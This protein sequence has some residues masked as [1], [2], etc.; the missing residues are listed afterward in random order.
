M[1]KQEQVILLLHPRTKKILEQHNYKF[2]ENIMIIAPIGYLEMVWLI[3]NSKL[4][5]TDSGRLQKEAFF[6]KKTCIPLR[7]ETEWVELIE[8]KFNVLVGAGKT[9]IVTAYKNYQ[10]YFSTNFD[11]NL[12]G[13]AKASERIVKE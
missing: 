13:L 3:K 1:P 6:F 7:Y 4:V 2:S 8:H 10:T 12:Y 5:M 9:K 11:M